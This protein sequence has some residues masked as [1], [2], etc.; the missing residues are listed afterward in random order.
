MTQE[1]FSCVTSEIVIGKVHTGH[2]IENDTEEASYIEEHF[3]TQKQ[4]SERIHIH[5][6]PYRHHSSPNTSHHIRLIIRTFFT[7]TRDHGSA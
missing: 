7:F 2:G 3:K 6:R 1:G 4:D 5:L